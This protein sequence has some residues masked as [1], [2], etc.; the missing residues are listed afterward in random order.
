M[1]ITAFQKNS[2]NGGEEGSIFTA[3]WKTES[4]LVVCQRFGRNIKIV[5]CSASWMLFQTD[6]YVERLTGTRDRNY[7]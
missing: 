2:K 4:L 6:A 1:K 3:S 7:T 5:N